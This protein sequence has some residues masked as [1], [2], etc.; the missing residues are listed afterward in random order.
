MHDERI[1]DFQLIV[2]FDGPVAAGKSTLAKLTAKRLNYVYLTTGLLYRAIAMKVLEHDIPLMLV[3]A[4]ASEIAEFALRFSYEFVIV[5]GENRLQLDGIDITDAL[6]D[7]HLSLYASKIS[8]NQK[9]RTGL[10]EVQRK[11]AENGGVVAEGRD[12]GRVVFPNADLKY[13]VTADPVFRAEMR[14]RDLIATGETVTFDDV[15]LALMERDRLD[16]NSGVPSLVKTDDMEE[17]DTTHRR[18][19][20]T[21]AEI[22]ARVKILE[23]LK[24]DGKWNGRR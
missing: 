24:R 21:A 13:W 20:E 11:A 9:I 3:T 7:N 15:Y 6:K 18:L 14:R 19:D 4:M 10:L 8:K 5:D 22:A 16:M 1:N 12:T 23:G 17:I 2:T